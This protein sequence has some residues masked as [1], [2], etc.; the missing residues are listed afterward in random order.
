MRKRFAVL[1]PPGSDLGR[2][3]DALTR[4]GAGWLDVSAIPSTE[5]A[6]DADALFVDYFAGDGH[7]PGADVIQ[8]LRA[9]HPDVP[10]VAVAER[11]D[12]KLAAEAVSAGATDFLVRG[13]PLAERVS[14]LLAKLRRVIDLVDSERTLRHQDLR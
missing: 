13:E 5:A 14:T 7:R 4:A 2:L 3:R 11:G 8:E 6:D 10:I 1:E 9:S 12:V